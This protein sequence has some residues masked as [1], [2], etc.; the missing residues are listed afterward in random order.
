MDGRCWESVRRSPLEGSL[1]AMSRRNLPGT[2]LPAFPS[3]PAPPWRNWD[4]PGLGV[5]VVHGDEVVFAEWLGGQ[6]AGHGSPG[7]G[8]HPLPACYLPEDYLRKHTSAGQ[9]HLLTGATPMVDVHFSD[10]FD[11]SPEALEDYGAFNISLINDLP[12]FIDPFLLFNSEKPEYQTLHA[13][14]IKYLRFLCDHAATEPIRPGLLGAWFT[15]PE[16]KQNWL[17]YSLVGNQG[18]GLGRNF[19]RALVQNL[20]TVFTSF[21]R[22]EITRGSH[23]EKLCL[24]ESGIGRDNISDFTA[25]LIKE[26]L[27]TYTETFAR[28]HIAPFQRMRLSVPKVR[29]NYTTRTWMTKQFDLPRF[30]DDYVILT[31]KN[32]LTKDDSWI[33]RNG[34]LDDCST[35]CSSIPNEQLRAQLNAY[36]LTVLPEDP[37]RK[38]KREA[39]ARMVKKFPIVIDYYI[40][41]R[42]DNGDAAAATSDHKV[43]QSE[44]MYIRGVKSFAGLLERHTAFYHIPSNTKDEA[45]QR[46][47]FLKDVIENKG[48]HKIFYPGGTL[49]RRESD[50]QILF[51][52]VWFGTLSDISREVNDGRGPADYKVSRGATDKTIV[53]F[54]LASNRRLK[55]NLDRQV[56]I[57][58]K[59]SDADS[60][61][62]VILFFTD[63]ELDRVHRI[64]D[65]LGLRSDPDIVLI[66]GGS[67][68]KPSASTA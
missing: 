17:G 40:R 66:D 31:P 43:V 53:E 23:L 55:Q 41:Y 16:I 27:L 6:G 11:I 38:Q 52:L 35:V 42:E 59:A 33:S 5:A 30:G 12:L 65:E 26:F 54:K 36:L 57:Y 20:N 25:N 50:L 29:F 68:N 60:K 8:A 9:L 58:Q 24:V 15:F 13:N 46:V 44:S 7:R 48:G 39:M 64:L 4:L 10:H 63:T 67:D 22:E 2:D 1:A 21:G 34:L 19:A 45:R 14:M 18:R 47:E 28:S 32:I 61:L 62:K 49:I 37:T 56:E 51:R 3:T